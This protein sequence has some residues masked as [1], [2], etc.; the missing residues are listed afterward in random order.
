MELFRK[1][2]GEGMTIVP[3]HAFREKCLLRQTRHS[4]ARW[5]GR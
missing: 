4:I 3:G 2:N 1:L 5:V